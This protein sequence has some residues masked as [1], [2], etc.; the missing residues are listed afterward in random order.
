MRN[1]EEV[2]VENG[3]EYVVIYPP[4]YRHHITKKLVYP[5]N[6]KRFRIMIPI[7]KYKHK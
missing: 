7:E 4:F 5:K 1:N 3:K 6:S 2:V